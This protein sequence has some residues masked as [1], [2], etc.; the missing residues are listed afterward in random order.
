MLEDSSAV[1]QYSGNK[2]IGVAIITC[3]RYYQCSCINQ[4]TIRVPPTYTL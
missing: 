3:M 4:F 2:H 1:V